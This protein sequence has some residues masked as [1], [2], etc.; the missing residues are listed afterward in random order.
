MRQR[1]TSGITTVEQLLSSK[2][3]LGSLSDAE[4]ASIFGTE[5]RHISPAR[6]TGLCCAAGLACAWQ[7]KYLKHLPEHLCTG[8]HSPGWSIVAILQHS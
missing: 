8:G 3:F 6:N 1:G 4:R 5:P 7:H 2:T